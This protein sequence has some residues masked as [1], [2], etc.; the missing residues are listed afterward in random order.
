MKK[1][2]LVKTFALVVVVLFIVVSFQPITALDTIS[3]EKKSGIVKI[4]NRK[5]LLFETIINIAN[6]NEIQDIIQKS[7]I[8]YNPIK[9]Q[10]LLGRFQKDII[11]A[12]KSND[13]LYERLTQL[14]DLP[15]DCEKDNTTNGSHLFLCLFLLPLLLFSFILWW[16]SL[17]QY[18]GLLFVWLLN[19]SS[20]LNCFWSGY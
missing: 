20:K 15:C 4:D 16:G 13:A 1:D 9:L 7:D 6:N 8:K 14:S 18:G 12:I 11:G 5:E 2:W 17:F 10:Q 19:I 3:L